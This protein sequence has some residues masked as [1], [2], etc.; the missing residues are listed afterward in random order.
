[1]FR[2]ET[3]IS[4]RWDFTGETYAREAKL[5]LALFQLAAGHKP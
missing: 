1:M 3:R 5:L 4:G 2:R